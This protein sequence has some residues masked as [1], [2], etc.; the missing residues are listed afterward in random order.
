MRLLLLLLLLNGFSVSAI[1]QNRVLKLDFINSCIVLSEIQKAEI[2]NE[3]IIVAD[4]DWL[5]I[6]TVSK[7]AYNSDKKLALQL[8]KKRNR[9][10]T[11]FL[12]AKGLKA[13]NV[14]YKYDLIERIWVHKPR[15]LESSVSLNNKSEKSCYSF[16]NNQGFTARLHNGNSIVF[17]ANS[18]D[19]FLSEKINICIEEYTS[20]I[21]FVKYGVTAQGD[22]GMLE[23]QGMYNVV[24]TCNGD[25]VKLRKGTHYNLLIRDGKD[26][27]PFYAFYGNEKGGEL[28]WL[29]KTNEKFTISTS[30]ETGEGIEVIDEEEIG[31]RWESEVT[32]LSGAFSK[33]GWINCDRFYDEEEKITMNFKIESKNPIRVYVVFHDIN[34]VMPARKIL[35]GA[36]VISGIPKNQNI[37][38][39]AV[40]TNEKNGTGEIG[41][42]KTISKSTQKVEF[43]TETISDLEMTRLLDDV[44]Y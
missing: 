30:T 39:V 41:F 29:K 26:S 5:N 11:K 36:Y 8:A 12:L 44:I 37:S 1:N 23:S 31:I 33:L 21:D 43:K 27:K 16:I 34:S 10:I 19:A 4:G 35:N 9:V 42:F 38:V 14:I 7:S 32:V 28:T 18:F 22:K 24:A 15:V 13:K 2:V 3:Y 17:K 20:K 40:N 6:Q 25:K